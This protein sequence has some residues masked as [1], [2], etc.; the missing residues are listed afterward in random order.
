MPCKKCIENGGKSHSFD[1]IGILNDGIT[2]IYYTSP[3]RAEEVK[4]PDDELDLFGEHL[5]DTLPNK[6]IWI[7]DSKGMKARDFISGSSGKKMVELI[8]EKYQDKLIG[9]YIVNPTSILKL[10]LNLIN[11]F[12]KND[13]KS[14]VHTCSLGLIDTVNKLQNAGVSTK[15]LHVIMKLIQSI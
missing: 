15:D 6:W 12:I 2:H 13:I 9:V 1:K 11:P 8:Q 10:F 14:R 3:I 7:F 5:K 4:S